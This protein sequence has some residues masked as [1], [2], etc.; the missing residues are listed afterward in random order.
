MNKM[1]TTIILFA[2]I[3]MMTACNTSVNK[4]T[5]TH[6]K[7]LAQSD[8]FGVLPEYNLE[9]IVY[10]NPEEI[11][12]EYLELAKVEIQETSHENST[13]DVLERLKTE[14]KNLGG[15]GILLTES[16]VSEEG[17]N[18]THTIKGIAVYA[19]GRIPEESPIV[20]L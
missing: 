12:G 15:N 1:I 13:T 6:V 8:V 4:S 3:L 16:E 7:D 20:A 19:L 5:T 10:H 14:A 18:K 9:V 11:E 17:K 2:T